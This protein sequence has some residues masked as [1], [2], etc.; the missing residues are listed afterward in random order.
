MLFR[1]LDEKGKAK[2]EESEP[3]TSIEELVNDG[4]THIKREF[5]RRALCEDLTQ[6]P[7]Y[8]SRSEPKIEEPSRGR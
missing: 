5:Y 6:E 8:E 4:Y 1:S 2:I 3:Y 7:D